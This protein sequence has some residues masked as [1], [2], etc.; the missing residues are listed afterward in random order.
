MNT[1]DGPVVEVHVSN[2]HAREEFRHHS[3]ISRRADGIIVGC[4]VQG[5]VF[6][7]QRIGAMLATKV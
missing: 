7:V 3:Y 6:G 4:G 5:Y 2:I 1:F